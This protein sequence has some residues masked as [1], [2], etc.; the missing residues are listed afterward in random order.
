M[1]SPN[2]ESIRRNGYRGYETRYS[3]A[4]DD[5]L[6]QVGPGTPCGEYLRRYWHP[7]GISDELGSVPKSVRFFGEDL[8][9]FR[10]AGG[11]IGLVHRRCPHRRASLEYIEVVDAATLR[12]VDVVDSAVVVL[13]A[14]WFGDV[15]LIDNRVLDDR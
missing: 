2:L 1:T 4:A 9:L 12:P 15:R 7:V 14:A 3:A 11:R 5:E 13:V 8:V 10:D 6:T